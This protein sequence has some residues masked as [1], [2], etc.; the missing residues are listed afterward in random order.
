MSKI[1]NIMMLRTIKGPK[2]QIEKVSAFREHIFSC[3]LVCDLSQVAGLSLI[4][5]LDSLDI[6]VHL[7]SMDVMGSIFWG[8]TLLILKLAA[9]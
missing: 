8:P 1:V 3:T 5:I 4:M 9:H 6:Q 2:K 7:S